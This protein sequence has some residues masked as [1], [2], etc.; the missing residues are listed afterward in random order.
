[1]PKKPSLQVEPVKKTKAKRAPSAYNKYVK[2][3][4]NDPSIAKLGS[5]PMRMSKIGEMWRNKDKET[6]KSDVKTKYEP[7]KTNVRSKKMKKISSL[8][9]LE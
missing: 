9:D 5:A 3:H 1:M 2:E 8:P 4:M 6:S 7:L